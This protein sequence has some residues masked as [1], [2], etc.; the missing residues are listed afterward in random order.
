MAKLSALGYLGL[1]KEATYGT[2]LAPTVFIPF[3]TVKVEDEW[4]KVTDE[5]RRG[6][7][8]RDFGVFNTTRDAKVEFEGPCYPDVVGNVLL[9]IFGKD[10]VTGA[11][12]PYTHKFQINNATGPSYTVTDYNVLAGTNERRYPGA[13]IEEVSFKFD[14]D[15][16]LNVSTK[17]QAKAS[18]LVAKSTPT[19]SLTA[20][21]MG[22]QDAL[23]LNGVANNNLLGGEVTFKREVDLIFAGNNTQDPTKMIQG[24]MEATGKLTF[25]VDD[26]TEFLLFLNGTQ[27]SVELTFTITAGTLSLDFMFTKVDV[28]KATVDRGSES[29][30]VDLEF[31]ALYNTTDAGMGAVTLI[32]AVASY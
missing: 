2:A 3:N 17:M 25:D 20:P 1:A 9:G 28:T 19:Q 12:A 4:K 15:T 8:S 27:Q 32:N 6:V 14:P 18:T 11:A 26:E 22:W 30:R 7:L 29:I 31:R 13:A 24:R 10:T 16:M 21:F 5:G 23:K